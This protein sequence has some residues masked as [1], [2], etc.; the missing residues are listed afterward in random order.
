MSEKK[1][2][3]EAVYPETQPDFWQLLSRTTENGVTQSTY[4]TQLTGKGSILRTV[5]T[6]SD[7]TS[8]AM[9]HLSGARLNADRAGNWFLE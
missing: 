5:T 8:E 1:T 6:S 4:A 9:V 2:F 7:G 3:Q